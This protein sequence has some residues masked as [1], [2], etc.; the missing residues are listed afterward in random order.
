MV[1]V[2]NVSIFFMV[3]LLGLTSHLAM[4]MVIQ[5]NDITWLGIDLELIRAKLLGTSEFASDSLHNELFGKNEARVCAQL[6]KDVL[7]QK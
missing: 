5:L 4:A 6:K 2:Q 3:H 1:G 7:G